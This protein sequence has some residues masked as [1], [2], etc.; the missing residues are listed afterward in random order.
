VNRVFAERAFSPDFAR[1]VQ[2][3]FSGVFSEGV[4]CERFSIVSTSRPQSVQSITLLCA[5]A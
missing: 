4:Q 2:R 1:E 5:K 3:S